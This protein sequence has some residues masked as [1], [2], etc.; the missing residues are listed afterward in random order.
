MK[1]KAIFEVEF[2]PDDMI[3]EED[4]KEFYDNDWLK[5]MKDLY[6]DEGMGVFDEPFK[7][8]KIVDVGEEDEGI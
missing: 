1:K 4:L 5:C 3:G 7:L 8:V 6:E 2:E